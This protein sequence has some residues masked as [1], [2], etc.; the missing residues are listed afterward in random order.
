MDNISGYKKQ[1][2]AKII[3]PEPKS[4]NM[5]ECILCDNVDKIHEHIDFKK[6]LIEINLRDTLM[7]NQYKIIKNFECLVCIFKTIDINDWKLHIL[8]KSHLAVCHNTR[9]YLYSYVCETIMCKTLLYG[10][11]VSLSIHMKRNHSKEFNINCISILMDEVM[12]HYISNEESQLYY[13]G[14]CNRLGYKPIHSEAEFLAIT[15]SNYI[16]HYCKYCRV[17]FMC[18]PE[19]LDSHALSVQHTTLKCIAIIS[20]YLTDEYENYIQNLLANS[21]KLPYTV[22]SKYKQIDKQ[23]GKCL[24]CCMEIDLNC[25]NLVLHLH[26]CIYKSDIT[27]TNKTKFMKYACFVCANYSVDINDHI[28]H[29]T[30]YDHLTKCYD[31]INL[32]S[33]FCEPCCTYIYGH[34]NDIND[35]RDLHNPL[36]PT[37]FP[38]FS[39]FMAKVFMDINSQF[40]KN[41]FVLYASN[42]EPNG[43][44]T[45][46]SFFCHACKVEFKS[47]YDFELHQITNEH[48]ILVFTARVDKEK[49]LNGQFTLTTVSEIKPTKP[50]IQDSPSCSS[51]SMVNELL[52]KAGV[53]EGKF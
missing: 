19:L 45:H 12:N 11:E 37:E 18:P 31:T 3:K 28:S 51:W 16:E 43:S 26:E 29:I 36:S 8:S 25:L 42:I 5:A 24:S 46:T 22:L 50:V 53:N 6:I 23:Y 35:H 10:S 1:K 39:T 48:I 4:R 14:H 9:D 44:S 17:T 20:E 7:L 41:E 38:M 2:S 21:F 34:E 33:Y 49:C 47:N 32:Y 52:Q 15:R 40:N 27:I 30:S 13:C